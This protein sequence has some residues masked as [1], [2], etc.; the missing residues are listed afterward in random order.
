MRYE[1]GDP[2]QLRHRFWDAMAESPFVMLQLDSAPATAAPMTA[3]LDRHAS[4]A[5]WFFTSRDNHFASGGPATATFVAKGHDLFARFSGTL[6]EET[7]RARL[8]KE[9]NPTVAAWFKGG[10]DDPA[11]LML[12]MDLGPAA[13]WSGRI[14]A[15]NAVRMAL[16]L[17]VTD[18]IKGD[19]AET[20]I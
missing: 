17:D 15:L 7:D 18:R 14:G 5:I 3:Q 20:R 9:W 16:G 13:I 4:H 19:Y 2:A 12:R 8:D 1:Q 6:V 10:K 11:L